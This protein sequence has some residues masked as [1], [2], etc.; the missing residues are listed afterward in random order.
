MKQSIKYTYDD[1]DR[2]TSVTYDN[3]QRIVYAY[4]AAGNRTSVT[5]GKAGDELVIEQKSAQR[6]VAPPIVPQSPGV[7]CTQC[8][9]S[10]D[11]S[12]KF[13]SECGA[14][15]KPQEEDKPRFCTNC[16]SPLDAS[17][18]FCTECG[19]RVN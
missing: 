15:V 17:T 11:S 16:G 9:A 7:T 6:P 12:Q 14:K 13:C 5:I 2:L 3:G 4:D 18:A 19:S 10:L 8:G 1:L